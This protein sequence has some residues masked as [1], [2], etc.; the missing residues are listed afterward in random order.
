MRIM[1]TLLL[2]GIWAVAIAQAQP[3]GE[4]AAGA[5]AGGQALPCV[6]AADTP[7]APAGE[8]GAP[9][10]QLEGAKTTPEPCE[11]QSA[12]AEPAEDPPSGET[13]AGPDA[14]VEEDPGVEASADEEFMPGDEISED[15]PVPLPADI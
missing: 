6:P 11:E 12:G 9:E 2:P 1:L 14:T 5:E 7:Q 8:T 13:V 3:A 15:Y 4:P 10:G